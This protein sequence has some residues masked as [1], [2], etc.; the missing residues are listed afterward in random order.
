[1]IS[2]EHL[3]ESQRDISV[4]VHEKTMTGIKKYFMQN[5][6]YSLGLLDLLSVTCRIEI[7]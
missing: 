5:I 6:A 4:V 7:E 3:T 2:A 1:M